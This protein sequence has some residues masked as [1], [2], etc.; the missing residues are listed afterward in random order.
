[1]VF[2]DYMWQNIWTCKSEN[3]AC[4]WIRNWKASQTIEDVAII[5]KRTVRVG[6]KGKKP[7]R[8]GGTNG[9]IDA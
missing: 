4:K 5:R 9:I 7:E 6:R 1:M 3:A 2:Q 8:R